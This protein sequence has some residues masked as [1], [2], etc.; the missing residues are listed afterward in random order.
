MLARYIA[1]L[2]G[3]APRFRSLA[4]RRSKCRRVEGGEGGGEGVDGGEGYEQ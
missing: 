1:L 4:L 3:A 2:A